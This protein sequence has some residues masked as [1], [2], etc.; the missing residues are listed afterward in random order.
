VRER[1]D[2]NKIEKKIKIRNITDRDRDRQM[3][4][5]EIEERK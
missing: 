3:I 1:E 4:I 2:V 5:K